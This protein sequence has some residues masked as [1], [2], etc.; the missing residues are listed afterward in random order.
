MTILESSGLVAAEGSK[1]VTN[2]GFDPSSVAG[3]RAS[4]EVGGRD[5]GLEEEKEK[6]SLVA[7]FSMIPPRRRREE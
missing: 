3:D 2:W 7:S 5:K 4:L 6:E 1:T